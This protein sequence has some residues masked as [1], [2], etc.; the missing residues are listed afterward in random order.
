MPRRLNNFSKYLLATHIFFSFN[1]YLVNPLAHLS[2]MVLN[3][4]KTFLSHPSLCLQVCM[5]W[6]VYGGQKTTLESKISAPTTIGVPGFKPRLPGWQ[7]KSPWRHLTR[8]WRILISL[9]CNAYDSSRLTCSELDKCLIFIFSGFSSL[10]LFLVR[11]TTTG[12][13]QFSSLQSM[14]ALP[15]SLVV[16]CKVANVLAGFGKATRVLRFGHTFELLN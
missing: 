9:G 12:H 16:A 2:T 5:P 10:A 15:L 11:G 14:Q 13:T 8:T 3:I 6:P 4:F 1:T 7:H